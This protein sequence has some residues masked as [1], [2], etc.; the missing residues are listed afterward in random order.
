MRKGGAEMPHLTVDEIL[1]F[2]SLTELN[3]E[4]RELSATVNSHIRKC[5]KCLK[6][7]RAFQLIYDEFSE[8]NMR[9]DFKGFI[10][11]NISN[12]KVENEQSAEI[13]EALNEF[14]GFR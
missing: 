3:N 9:G 8:L 2:V 5:K 11:E 10:S 13:V 12:I 4:A 6:I 14:D 1:N 7:V